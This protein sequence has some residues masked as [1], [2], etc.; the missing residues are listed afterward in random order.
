MKELGNA[1]PVKPRKNGIQLPL[2]DRHYVECTGLSAKD[3]ISAFQNARI[4]E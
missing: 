1:I 4:L 2:R 3:V